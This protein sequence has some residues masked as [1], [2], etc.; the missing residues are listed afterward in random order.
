MARYTE[1][2]KRKANKTKE[3][4]D[5]IMF[6]ILI[7]FYGNLIKTLKWH[8]RWLQIADILKEKELWL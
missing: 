4:L 2:E 6:K 8:T 1:S 3:E 7:E 5:S